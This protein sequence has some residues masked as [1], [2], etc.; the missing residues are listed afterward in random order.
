MTTLRHTTIKN[1]SLRPLSVLVALSLAANGAAP[2]LAYPSAVG[3]KTSGDAVAGSSEAPR[4]QFAQ[5]AT[6]PAGAAPPGAPAASDKSVQENLFWES[7]QKSNSPADY[8]AYLDAFPNGL[9]APLAKNRMAAFSAPPA[10]PPGAPVAQPVALVAALAPPAISP[11][12]L[13]AEIGTFETEQ[14]LNMGPPMRMEI[15][16]RLSAIGLYAG[17][18]DGDLGNGARSAIAEWQKR[19]DTAPTGQLG[20][21]Q[22]AELRAESEG[23]YEQMMAS[24]PP[25]VAPVYA[26]VRVYHAYRPVEHSY[27]APAVVG[28]LGGL[29]IGILGAKFGGKFGGKGGGKG[30]GKKHR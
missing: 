20:P 28:L 23:P 13:K 30:G 16:Q 7:A 24:R 8:R 5:N 26:P 17:P 27:A 12:A 6:P 21:L 18:I 2:A 22:L 3:A 4:V 15:Q 25:I 1:W 11:E 14:G 9:Y 10:A 29:A 19:H